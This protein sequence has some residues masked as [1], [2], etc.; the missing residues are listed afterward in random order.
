MNIQNQNKLLTK[1]VT[2]CQNKINLNLT[3]LQNKILIASALIFSLV[4]IYFLSIIHKRGIF[5]KNIKDST[6]KKDH[7]N[8][9][10]NIKRE[11][12]KLKDA[13][14]KTKEDVIEAKNEIIKAKNE[15][16]QGL[17][18]FKLD[19]TVKEKVVETA[20]RTIPKESE[21]SQR[22]L[23]PKERIDGKAKVEKNK[24]AQPKKNL[25]QPLKIKI[26][27]VS[28]IKNLPEGLQELDLTECYN[29]EVD[30]IPNLP[31]T[32][33]KLRL[34]C[35]N[36]TDK[37]IA[38]LPP[39]LEQLYLFQCHKLTNVNF[40]YKG[41][42]KLSIY[43]CPYLTDLNLNNFLQLEKFKLFGAK[44]FT[45]FNSLPKDLKKLGLF[46]CAAL[47]ELRSL[48]THLEELNLMG[49]DKLQNIDN[50]PTSLR[51]LHFMSTESYA[52]PNFILTDEMIRDLPPELEDLEISPCEL[53]HLNGL[54]E[55]LKK[56]KLTYCKFLE[57]DH[58]SVLPSEIEELEISG[59]Q[60]SGHHLTR[61]HHLP[62]G[63]KK[64]KL[65]ALSSLTDIEIRDL[66]EL[67]KLEL[68]YCES[69]RKANVE[70]LPSTL[71]EFILRD[72][73][74]ITQIL[75]LPEELKKLILSGKSL[76][77]VKI[78]HLSKLEELIT[79]D[80]NSSYI[81]ISEL[82]QSLITIQ[83]K[84]ETPPD[85]DLKFSSK[86][87]VLDLSFSKASH[88]N[89]KAENLKKL[90][91]LECSNLE[92]IN[93]KELLGLEE[94]NLSYCSKIELIEGMSDKL[95]KL[96]LKDCNSLGNS[97]ISA[98]PISIEEVDLI[99]T[100]IKMLKINNHSAIIKIKE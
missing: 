75:D 40:L 60:E 14:I 70:N 98:L 94:L 87:E 55:K 9:Q 26:N 63:L 16:V 45:H 59:N 23:L 13:V 53:S 34:N 84:F 30:D 12:A 15:M 64:L 76:N 90:I 58:L 27:D 82:P 56:L 62:K 99:G 100:K 54:P 93:I 20:P 19:P 69:L 97:G 78:E 5:N 74:E 31:Q 68:N 1:Y 57:N 43:D 49:C 38:G 2:F 88:L 89:I 67:K 71:E 79:Y 21:I 80:E 85:E 73:D 3:P 4:G 36:L 7:E 83:L 92:S 8:E 25:A 52:W 77:N 33:I 86:L 17:E 35:T 42:K 22:P 41:L 37:D 72:C 48:P 6:P 18:S 65:Y 24:D 91:L 61:I 44:Q 29:F 66:L 51:K 10:T 28:E 96:T 47:E 39:K 11:F 46:Y 81:K 32:L 50:L 95:K